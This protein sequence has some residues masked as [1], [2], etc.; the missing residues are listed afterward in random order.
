MELM[1]HRV[2]GLDV[3]K[4]SVVACIRTMSGNKP[5]R[6]CKTFATT[7]D[8]LVGLLEWLTFEHDQRCGDG[9]DGGLLA[10]GME[11]FERW[12]VR[13]CP[14][15]RRPHQGGSWPQDGH[16]RR[17]VDRRSCGLRLDQGELRARGKDGWTAH[18]D[19]NS[20][21]TGSRADAA[22]STDPEDA[23]RGE[24]SSGFGAQRHDGSE[25]A[26]HDRSDDRRR[27]RP[28]QTGGAGQSGSQSQAE[29]TLR[30]A[31]WAVD[32]Q[33][34]I[35]SQTPSRPMGRHRSLDQGPGWGSRSPPGAHGQGGIGPTW[36]GFRRRCVCSNRFPA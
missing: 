8:G 32:R 34:P 13:A 30:R 7:T 25:R 24:H 28:A 22:C 16:E 17:D 35:Y 3:H 20:Q 18:A 21:A 6:E 5:S 4:N 19:A 12:G 29:G 27:A 33:S 23:D 36:P 15:E 31:A 9:G 10:A 2:A 14:G 1:H 11:D 26:A